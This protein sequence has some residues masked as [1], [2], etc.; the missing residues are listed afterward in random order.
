MYKLCP[1]KSWQG[2]K[3]IDNWRHRPEQILAVGDLVLVATRA[4]AFYVFDRLQH[5]ILRRFDVAPVTSLLGIFPPPPPHT[6]IT[7]I[8]SDLLLKSGISHYFTI[9]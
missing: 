6:H 8:Q 4:S 1:P 3:F 9:G 5:E 7:Y 2:S